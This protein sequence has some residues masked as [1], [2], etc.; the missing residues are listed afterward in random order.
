MALVDL[1]RGHPQSSGESGTPWLLYTVIGV[2]AAVI[3]G[4]VP[5]L[6][7][8]RR[9]ALRGIAAA[10]AAPARAGAGQPPPARGAE[11]PTEK[12]RMPG[13]DGGSRSRL[14]GDP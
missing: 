14:S 11:A 13:G 5:L 7:R 9:A 1:G 8:A 3:I 2:S 4:A 12:L 10:R 6:L